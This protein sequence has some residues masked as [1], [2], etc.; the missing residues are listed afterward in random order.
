MYGPPQAHQ[1]ARNTQAQL[2][3]RALTSGNLHLPDLG[4]A[5]DSTYYRLTCSMQASGAS[6]D[7]QLLVT[8]K[9]RY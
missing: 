5:C 9:P 1:P 3:L 6:S 2:C 8:H 7:L 4:P